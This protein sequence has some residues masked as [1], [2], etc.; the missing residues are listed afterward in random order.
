MIF[1]QVI[2]LLIVLGIAWKFISPYVDEP[3]RSIVIVLS[4][5]AFCLW[6]LDAF[7]IFHLPTLLR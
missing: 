3:F 1:I 5:L 6:L 7:G 4:I 2:V